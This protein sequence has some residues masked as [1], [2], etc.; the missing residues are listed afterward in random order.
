MPAELL[1]FNLVSSV[2]SSSAA[3]QIVAHCVVALC[4]S[5]R[6]VRADFGLMAGSSLPVFIAGG[7]SAAALALN[8]VEIY[9]AAALFGVSLVLYVLCSL[10]LRF[11][12]KVCGC[13]CD[14]IMLTSC[15]LFFL[16][17]P[18]EMSNPDGNYFQF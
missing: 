15:F 18:K 11:S 9:G 14:A 16:R 8:L 2:V 17:T 5:V 10:W 13:S 7:A 3:A 4:I 1:T 12:S 6:L